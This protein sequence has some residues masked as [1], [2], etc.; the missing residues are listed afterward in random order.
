MSLI[1][2]YEALDLDIQIRLYR[3]KEFLSAIHSE[4]RF[5]VSFVRT[6]SKFIQNRTSWGARPPPRLYHQ[7]RR[8][9]KKENKTNRFEMRLTDS[10]K[11][12]LKACANMCNC[13]PTDYMRLLLW[14]LRPA[15]LP[16]EKYADMLEQLIRLNKN[17][18][19]LSAEIKL[20]GESP[21][22]EIWFTIQNIDEV[23]E[24]IIKAIHHPFEVIKPNAV[25]MLLLKEAHGK[26]CGD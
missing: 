9:M 3:Q 15:R 16:K 21:M 11:E 1:K 2:A 4:H 24:Q 10:E 20:T 25:K 8:R 6:R 14:G 13:T 5:C 22:N 26:E 19:A 17:L 23:T 7:T 12:K 18:E